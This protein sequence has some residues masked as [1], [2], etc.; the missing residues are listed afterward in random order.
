MNS[1]L[2]IDQQIRQQQQYEDLSSVNKNNITSTSLSSVERKKASRREKDR[3]RKNLAHTKRNEDTL[4]IRT[5]STIEEEKKTA[6]REKDREQK[7]RK[8]IQKLADLRAYEELCANARK[9]HSERPAIQQEGQ[10]VHG[11]IPIDLQ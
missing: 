2:T 7:K 10:I 5:P 8:Q 4:E 1:K 6:R 11:N 9:M 3:E